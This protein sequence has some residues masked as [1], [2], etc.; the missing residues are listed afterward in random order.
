MKNLQF[1][2]AYLQK[3][4]DE[5]DGGGLSPEGDDK[6]QLITVNDIRH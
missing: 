5:E 2:M 4:R 3:I 1:M 6:R